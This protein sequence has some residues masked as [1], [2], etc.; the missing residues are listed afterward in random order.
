MR[1]GT[2]VYYLGRRSDFTKLE[3]SERYSA[4]HKNLK[5]WNHSSLSELWFQFFTFSR[6]YSKL[7]ESSSLLN[8]VLPLRESPPNC[9]T[10]SSCGHRVTCGGEVI[11]DA[12]CTDVLPQ[13]PRL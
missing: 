3:L 11:E 10:D 12:D 1:H 8:A 7:S 5:N 4:L 6:L 2:Q 13:K 9:P